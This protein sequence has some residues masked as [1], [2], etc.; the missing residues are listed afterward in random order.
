M[1]AEVVGA[2]ATQEIR[3]FV[4]LKRYSL[5]LVAQDPDMHVDNLVEL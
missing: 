5:T 2:F 3:T 1:L 4:H